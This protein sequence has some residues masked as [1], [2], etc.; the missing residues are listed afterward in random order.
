MNAGARTGKLFFVVV[1]STQFSKCEG[2]AIYLDSCS[3]E[4]HAWSLYTRFLHYPSHCRR[5]SLDRCLRGPFALA[6]LESRLPLIAS[7]SSASFLTLF[8]CHIATAVV[9]S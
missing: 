7:T 2:L 4:K 6:S 5:S 3:S 9:A 8:A 1:N